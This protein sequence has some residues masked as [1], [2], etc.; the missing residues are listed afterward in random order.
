MRP[1]V[2]K[3]SIK[4]LGITF[5]VLLILVAIFLIYDAKHDESSFRNNIASV[6]TASVTSISIFPK[7]FNHK[8][9]KIFKAG[10]LWEEYLTAGKTVFVPF[11]KVQELLIQL[12]SIRPLSVAAQTK[13]KWDEFKVG[14]EGTR[15]KVFEGNKIALDM[16]IGKFSY[17]Q[18]RTM[19]TY[20]RVSGDD[21]VYLVKGFLDFSFNHDADY[22][23][24]DNVIQ[25]NFENW[26][27]LT[28]SYPADSS[29]Q[30]VK[31]NGRWEIND[32]NVDSAKIISYLTSISNLS[33]PNFIDNSDQSLLNKA[34]YTL[35]IQSSAFGYINVSAYEDSTELVI[36]SSQ[37]K[38]TCFDGKKADAWKR[39]F[40]G[41]SSFIEKKDIKK[42]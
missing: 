29:F 2:N 30:L 10:S 17:Q 22:F 32:K 33:I 19:T 9:I 25:D 41:K 40:A 35:K 4:S 23:R 16:V 27:K 20:V 42:S 5:I 36:I 13:D 34:K 11:P 15:V 8:E 28:F 21:N 39:I 26:S 3:L 37:H 24:D 7:S 6:D 18:P 38:E 12:T 31:I 14:S 1:M